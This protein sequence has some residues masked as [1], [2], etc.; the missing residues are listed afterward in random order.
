[1]KV[2]RT[3]GSKYNVDV[4][5][6]ANAEQEDWKEGNVSF[7]PVTL[8][9]TFKRKLLQHSFFCFEFNFFIKEVLKRQSSYDFIWANDLPTLFPAYKIAKKLNAQLVYDSHEIYVETINQ[10]FPKK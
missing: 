6:L 10:F 8:K 1:M 7:M 2:V 4:F 3:L 5:F 9:K